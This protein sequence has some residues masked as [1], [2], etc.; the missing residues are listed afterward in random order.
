MHLEPLKSQTINM[1]SFPSQVFAIGSGGAAGVVKAL[2]EGIPS[3]LGNSVNI[4]RIISTCKQ[5]G[6]FLFSFI[7]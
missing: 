5:N 4:F 7:G 2:M 6:V 3:H 1:P